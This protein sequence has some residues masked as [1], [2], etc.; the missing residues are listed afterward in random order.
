MYVLS[1]FV[2]GVHRRSEC[3][4]A[5]ATRPPDL[6]LGKPRSRNIFEP[7]ALCFWAALPQTMVYRLAMASIG[8]RQSRAQVARI[9][10]QQE[11]EESRAYLTVIFGDFLHSHS[12]SNDVFHR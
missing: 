7:F 4:Q 12:Y 6:A 9:S 8:R 2:F 11:I 10:H 1:S 5:N 3:G